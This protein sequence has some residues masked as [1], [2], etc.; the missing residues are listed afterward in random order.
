MPSLPELN[1]ICCTLSLHHLLQVLSFECS[2]GRSFAHSTRCQTFRQDGALTCCDDVAGPHH[3]W[4]CCNQDQRRQSSFIPD[5]WEEQ[6][7]HHQMLSLPQNHLAL[8]HQEHQVGVGHCYL[9]ALRPEHQLA[10]R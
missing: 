6:I 8:H 10:S 5:C 1:H 7:P 9:V 4:L 2:C 3:H